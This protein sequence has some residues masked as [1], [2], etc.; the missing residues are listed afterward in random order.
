MSGFLALSLLCVILVSTVFQIIIWTCITT[1][2]MLRI[3]EILL[4]QELK[5]TKATAEKTHR[6]IYPPTTTATHVK[7]SLFPFLTIYH[8][9]GLLSDGSAVTHLADSPACWHRSPNSRQQQ[10]RWRRWRAERPRGRPR[11]AELQTQPHTMESAGVITA[12][13]ISVSPAAPKKYNKKQE[14]GRG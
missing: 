2:V 13:L 12:G 7:S 11:R 4:H 1:C 14:R 8:L 5:Q 6:D 9:P 10:Q 3:P